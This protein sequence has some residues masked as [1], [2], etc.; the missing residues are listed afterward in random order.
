MSTIDSSDP[1]TVARPRPRSG[2]GAG[3][4]GQRSPAAAHT[5]AEPTIGEPG[6]TDGHRAAD[7]TRDG[8]DARA[9]R[10]IPTLLREL[11]DE[12]YGLVQQEL[13]LARSEIAREVDEATSAIKTSVMGAVM[14]VVG[15]VILAIAASA[16]VYA[17]MLEGGMSPLVAGW[18]APLI[19]AVVALIAGGVMMQQARTVTSAKHWR[20]ERTEQSLR[21]T[22]EWAGRTL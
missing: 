5:V 11:R 4:R 3:P 19:I 22:R 9:M 21:E 16:G 15:L 20:P 18:L 14:L 7:S 12:A 8:A 1:A 13:L 10:S 17:A 6:M 2:T